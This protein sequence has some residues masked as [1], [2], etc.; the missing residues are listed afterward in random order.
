MS[1]RR[2]A[3]PL[4]SGVLISALLIGARAFAAPV[5]IVDEPCPEPFTPSATFNDLVKALIIEPHHI[6]PEEFR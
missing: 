2:I 3:K 4:F 1:D 6:T 5:G